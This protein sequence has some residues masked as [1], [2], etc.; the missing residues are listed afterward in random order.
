MVR[1]VMIIEC[2][3]TDDPI[4]CRIIDIDADQQEE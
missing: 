4:S 2:H 1:K 3:L